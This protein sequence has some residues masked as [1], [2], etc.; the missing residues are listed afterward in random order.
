M[1]LRL[2]FVARH[3]LVSLRNKVLCVYRQEY[4]FAISTIYIPRCLRLLVYNFKIRAL[5]WAC[6]IFDSLPRGLLVCF[7][8]SRLQIFLEV[9]TCFIILITSELYLLYI[10]TSTNIGLPILTGCCWT[11][12]FSHSTLTTS[13]LCKPMI[14]YQ[15]LQLTLTTSDSNNITSSHSI[16]M[17]FPETHFDKHP[18]HDGE[19]WETY[20]LENY[21]S[22]FSLL[23]RT[24]LRN[25]FMR[26]IFENHISRTISE[27]QFW[28]SYPRY[29]FE[30]HKWDTLW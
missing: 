5:L 16:E 27:I 2:A 25:T 22:R 9:L 19:A 28:E 15:I 24:I 11:T 21:F 7:V 30:I 23:V 10:L 18:L 8:N 3:T 14:P 13:W 26:S 4:T 17:H 12:T 6:Y 1:G 29:T 20:F